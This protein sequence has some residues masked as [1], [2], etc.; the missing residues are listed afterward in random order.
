MKVWK[1]KTL[2][3]MFLVILLHLPMIHLS[4]TMIHI[5]QPLIHLSQTQIH[6]NQALFHP[7][8]IDLDDEWAK[9]TLKDDIAS[10]NGSND[11][12]RPGNPKFNERTD[13]TNVQLVKGMKFPNSKVFRKA[14]REYLIQHHIDIKWKLNEKKKISVHCK[15]NYGWRCYASMVTCTFEIKTLNPECTYPLSFQNEQVTSTYIA[16]RYL[17]DFSKNSN[18]E[19][20]GFKHHVM[21]QISIDLSLSQVYRLRK[22]ATGLITGNEEF[23]Y[24]LLRDYAEMIRRTDVGSNVILQ[25]EME[26][27][28][29]QPKFKSVGN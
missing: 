9:P 19:V 3:M 1:E 17:E 14:L 12:Q 4:L 24:S 28:N 25:I 29:A 8:N 5:N 7:P 10:M 15:N 22:T 26:D 27:E 11:E 23:Q 18:L 20:S 21:Q 16:N 13:M 2:V 6:L